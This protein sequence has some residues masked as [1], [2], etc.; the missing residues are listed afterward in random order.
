MEDTRI[1]VDP[2]SL[3]WKVVSIA[4][5]EAHTLALTGDG[6]VYSWGRGTFGRLGTGSELDQLFPT[7][8]EFSFNSR[9]D[10]TVKIVGVSAGSYHS[11]ALSGN[12]YVFISCERIQGGV[13]R[14][15]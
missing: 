3:S 14:V 1:Y 4:A 8:V 13:K 9:S 11:L 5:G 2:G 15:R 12:F 7:T 10:E 6:S